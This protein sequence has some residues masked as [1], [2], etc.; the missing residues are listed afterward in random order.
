MILL[1]YPNASIIFQLNC[2]HFLSEIIHLTNSDKKDVRI[3]NIFL[4]SKTAWRHTLFF[5]LLLNIIK[6]STWIKTNC[7]IPMYLNTW[8]KRYPTNLLLWTVQERFNPF[9]WLNHKKI[10]NIMCHCKHVTSSFILGC[11]LVNINS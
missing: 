11:I 3:S 9:F 1:I 6:L 7:E 4:V 8:W 2:I 10:F 5:S